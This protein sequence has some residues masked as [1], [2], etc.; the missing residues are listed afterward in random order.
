MSNWGELMTLD[1]LKIGKSAII[2]TVSGDPQTKQHLLD[3]GLIPGITIK[4][5]K[6]APM[7]DPLEFELHDY[8]LT[9]R[10]DDAKNIKVKQLKQEELEIENEIIPTLSEHPGLGESGYKYHNKKDEVALPKDSVITF[11][12]VGNQN[13]GKTTL[14]N[15]LTGSNQH[16][17]NFPGV[18]VDR[19]DGQIRNYPNTL[20]TDLPG[21]YSMSAYTPEELISRDFI[22]N[23][24]P[25][26]IINVLD[27]TSI[28][29]GLYLTMQLLELDIPMVLALNMM[30]EID[31]ND[32]YIDINRLENELGIPVV[33]ISASKN[34][35]IDELIEHAVH[36]AKYQ[37]KPQR[38]DYC[39]ANVN[40]GAIH[41]CL[42]SIMHQI[43]DHA[44]E[45]NIP[46]RFAASKCAEGDSNIIERLKLDTNHKRMLNAITKQMEKERGL[47]KA[48][49]I[50]DMRYSFILKTVKDTVIKPKES[51]EQAFSTKLDKILTG[52][53]TAIPVFILIMVSIFLLTFE[54]IGPFLE[55]ILEAII[56]SI[57]NGIDTWMNNANVNAGLHSLVIDGVFKGVGSILSFLPVIIVLFFFLSILEDSG[58]MARVAFFMDKLLRKIGLSGR[59]IV[60]LLIGFGCSVPGV[61]STR[62]LPS[63]RDRKMTILLI[64]FMSCSAKL[65]IYAFFANAF[66]PAHPGLVMSLLYVLGIV[67]SIIIAFIYKNTI[68]KGEAVPFVMELPAYRLPSLKSV[69]QLLWEKAKDFLQRAFTI[70]FMASVVIWFLQNY[71]FKLQ[72]VTDTEESILA[73]IASFISPIL[74]PLGLGNWR[75]GVSLVSGFL[76][77]EAVVSTIQV[78]FPGNGIMSFL[79][80]AS[81]GALL[82]FCLLYVPCVAT[83][84][85]I[86][87]EL[88][89]KYA[90]FVVIFQCS[91][92][93]IFAYLTF[94]LLAAI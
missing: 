78:L 59:S 4:F 87:Q 19:K 76:A 35:G 54:V 21:I 25:N 84:S 10:K 44:I 14:F 65:P 74:A 49:C 43:E 23:E 11:A 8:K 22:L 60:P 36:V 88:G 69:G 93:W 47:D 50:A 45:A 42:H 16:V 26:G 51:K 72:I 9:L 68:F 40:G 38:Q 56:N 80:P 94:L 57:S 71:S 7:G 58:Y 61:M 55:G 48:E 27:A 29:R 86:K 67:I 90:I 39:D 18:T 52:K 20:I 24:K 91:I 5:I 66:F 28:E 64:P 81:A 13:A 62:T 31:N 3:M 75:I 82:V 92:A 83:I 63:E 46:L 73:N 32:G 79:S 89:N 2:K 34:Q 6:A 85:T 70:I 33:P 12:L 41:R 37:E 15:Q 17:G 1:E 30:D 77:K 53:Y